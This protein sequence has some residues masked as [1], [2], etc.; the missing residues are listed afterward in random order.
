MR[1]IVDLKVGESGYVKSFGDIKCACKLLTLGLLPST[2]VMVL[3][4]SLF[5]QTYYIKMDKQY[6]ALRKT[7]AATIELTD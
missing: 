3:R 6:L 4:K 2:K 5:G 1:T 7:E